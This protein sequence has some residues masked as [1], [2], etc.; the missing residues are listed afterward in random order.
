M[1]DTPSGNYPGLYY[2]QNPQGAGGNQNNDRTK[3]A[4]ALV[5]RKHLESGNTLKVEG[6]LVGGEFLQAGELL[7][8]GNSSWNP[9]KEGKIPKTRNTWKDIRE[10]SPLNKRN[11]NKDNGRAINHFSRVRGKQVGESVTGNPGIGV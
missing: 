9:T 11:V 8:R 2:S 1:S 3:D 7:E 10:P 6:F 4:I 5:N